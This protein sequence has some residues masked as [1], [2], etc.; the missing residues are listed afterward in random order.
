MIVI[1][2]TILNFDG[3]KNSVILNFKNLVVFFSLMR[4]RSE[5]ETHG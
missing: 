2:V 4:N 3:S 5:V 1:Y